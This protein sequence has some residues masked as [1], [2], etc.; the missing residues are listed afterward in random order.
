MDDLSNDDTT[1]FKRST[2]ENVHGVRRD[3][4]SILFGYENP[5]TRYQQ[6]HHGSSVSRIRIIPLDKRTIPIE[7]QKALYAHGIIG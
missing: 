4:W 3:V 5:S 2:T 7:L 6:N 1:Y